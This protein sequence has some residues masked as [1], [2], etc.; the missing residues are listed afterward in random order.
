[1][2]VRPSV[3]IT[4]TWWVLI[5][6]GG[7]PGKRSLQKFGTPYLFVQPLK[8]ATSNLVYNLGLGLAY[9]ETTFTTEIGG[10][11]TNGASKKIRTPISFCNRWSQKLQ[12]W[13]ITWVWGVAYITVTTLVPNLVGAGWATGAP[14]KLYR[15]H[16]HCTTQQLQKCNKTLNINV[17]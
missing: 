8:L 1:M 4:L 9:Q 6:G 10:V 7:G 11:R 2:S 5:G 3:Y 12:I 16:V 14:Q 17:N 15:D 13:Y